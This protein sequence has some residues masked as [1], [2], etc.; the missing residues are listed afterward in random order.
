MEKICKKGI[1]ISLFIPKQNT[2]SCII[3]EKVSHCDNMSSGNYGTLTGYCLVVLLYSALET[4]VINHTVTN[5]AHCNRSS[6]GTKKWIY[7]A[8]VSY[9]AKYFLKV[10]THWRFYIFQLHTCEFGLLELRYQQKYQK[11]GRH[12]EN[13][14]KGTKGN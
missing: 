6:A 8:V 5:G 9:T 14:Q 10:G 12:M 1:N 3:T 2:K 7:N 4:E 11:Q 13:F